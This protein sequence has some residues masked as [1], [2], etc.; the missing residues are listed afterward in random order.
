[1]SLENW[2]RETMPQMESDRPTIQEYNKAI[3]IIDMFKDSGAE[4]NHI[5]EKAKEIRDKYH[6]YN[7]G[8][9]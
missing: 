1:M 3:W 7:T 4:F 9:V 8:K 6:G 5:L 2:M